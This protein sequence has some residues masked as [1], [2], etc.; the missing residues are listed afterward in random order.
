MDGVCKSCGGEFY[1]LIFLKMTDGTYEYRCDKCSGVESKLG[2]SRK[3]DREIEIVEIDVER[4]DRARLVDFLI[5]IER[6]DRSIFKCDLI[7]R[8]EE[9]KDAIIE[10]KIDLDLINYVKMHGNDLRYV[11]RIRELA[12]DAERRKSREVLSFAEQWVL[13]EII[14]FYKSLRLGKVVDFSIMDRREIQ[15]LDKEFKEVFANM[16]MLRKELST[17]RGRR[18]YKDSEELLDILAKE[19]FTDMDMLKLKSFYGEVIRRNK[20]RERYKRKG[21]K[22]KK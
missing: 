14:D 18:L 21:K 9:N 16:D 1:G 2:F 7:D 22:K 15:E 10:D 4:E 17:E 8:I 13:D 3:G 5:A 12:M 19:E 20:S 11:M 6:E